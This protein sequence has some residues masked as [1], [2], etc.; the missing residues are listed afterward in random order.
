MFLELVFDT[1]PAV[2]ELRD[3][4]MPRPENCPL[5]SGC[6]PLVCERACGMVPLPRHEPPPALL[7]SE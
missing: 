2:V 4:L 7:A 1:G 3:F 5:R 6:D